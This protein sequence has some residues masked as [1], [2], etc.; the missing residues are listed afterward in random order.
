MFDIKPYQSYIELDKPI[1]YF[2]RKNQV[3]ELYPVL[4]KDAYDFLNCYNILTIDKN[5]VGNIEIIQSSY[6]QF[7]LQVVLGKDLFGKVE[8]HSVQY[9]QFITVMRLC[10][11]LDIKDAEQL[12]ITVN[13]KGKFLLIVKGIEIN[14][15]DFDNIIQLIQYQNIY[16][17]EDESELNPDFKKAVDEYYALRNKGQE[18]LTLERK[19]SIV[20]AHNGMLKKDL[21]EMTY[22]SFEALFNSVVQQ[23]D[24]VVNKNFEA[25]FKANGG[26]LKEPIEH[27]AYRNKKSRYAN[28][29]VNKRSIEKGFKNS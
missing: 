28:A 4:L 24:Y 5:T 3:I 11:K 17:Y 21:L 9:W 14:Y 1:P 10:F 15:K 19:M 6:L 23:I 27:F 12:K 20:S 13:D 26:K 25:N 7:L 2:T 8:K 29:F 18:P 22:Y 16:N